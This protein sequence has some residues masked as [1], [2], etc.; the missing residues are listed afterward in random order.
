MWA[1]P[2]GWVWIDCLLKRSATSKRECE[3][4]HRN[5]AFQ[6]GSQPCSGFEQDTSLVSLDTEGNASDNS[7]CALE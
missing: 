3:L 1:T 5:A 2:E 4:E 6:L 7:V